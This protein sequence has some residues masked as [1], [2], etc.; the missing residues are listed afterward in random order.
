[1]C[2]K[3]LILKIIIDIIKVLS[4][5]R[6]K[7]CKFEKNNYLQNFVVKFNYRKVSIFV[8]LGGK[9]CIIIFIDE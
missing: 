6:R 1:M 4:K 2:L 7:I 9:S 5:F 3:G 8:D